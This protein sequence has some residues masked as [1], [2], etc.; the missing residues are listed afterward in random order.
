MEKSQIIFISGGARSGKSSFAEK[1]ATTLA[2]QGASDLY[3]L[4]TAK[5]TDDE[6][7][8]RIKR[9]QIDREDGSY[10]WTT[11]ECSVDIASK[12]NKFTPNSIVLLDCVTILL[13]NELI[14]NGFYEENP[15]YDA[16]ERKVMS[17]IIDGIAALSNRVDTLIIVSNEVTYEPL[18]KEQTV[19][20]TY[21]SLL[22]L[23]HQ[24][25]VIKSMEGYLVESGIAIQMK[26][27]QVCKE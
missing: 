1:Y 26:G 2:E 10:P 15:D 21:S 23:L 27:E 13:A 8:D 20:A 7:I 9:H 14:K 17:S 22:G 4:A 5:Q 12:V 3:Y 24:N 19:V 6:M 18:R 16:I 11:V 25:I